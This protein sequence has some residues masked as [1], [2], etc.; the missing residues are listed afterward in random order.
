VRSL[1]TQSDFFSFLRALP[2]VPFDVYP[3]PDESYT[4]HSRHRLFETLRQLA[5]FIQ[6][7]QDPIEVLD[8]GS[9]P[10]PFLRILP[11]LWPDREFK[12]YATG[13]ASNE[14]FVTYLQ[15]RNIP[16][17]PINLDPELTDSRGLPTRLP[18]E[19]ETFDI[20]IATEVVEHLFNPTILMKESFRTSKVGAI[21]EVTTPNL[22]TAYRRLKFMFK[23]RSPNVPV[24]D[25]IMQI[26][27]S[28]WRPHLREFTVAEVCELLSLSGWTPKLSMTYQLPGVSRNFAAEVFYRTIN[29]LLPFG[30]SDQL[31]IAEK[32]R[33]NL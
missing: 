25:S 20:V 19:E 27:S 30:D 11:A 6:R 1:A 14:D 22:A 9:F 28:D 23:G 29:R 15:Q 16:F 18:I 21:I 26:A 5:P 17:F 24:K 32:T 3:G 8:I 7:Y 31:V 33:S 4:Y 10:G 12:F 2:K 13:L